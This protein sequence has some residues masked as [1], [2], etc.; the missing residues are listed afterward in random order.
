MSSTF[1]SLSGIFSFF[2]GSLLCR[3]SIS[4]VETNMILCVSLIFYAFIKSIL[5]GNS[6]QMDQVWSFA[7]IFYTF[8]FNRW[9]PRG[10]LMLILVII[11]GVRL[12]YNFWRKGGYS[13][14][15]DYRLTQLRETI[16]NPIH[17]G[18]FNFVFICCNQSVLLML[19][20][21]PCYFAPTSELNL[22]DLVVALVVIGF[23]LVETIADN[24]QWQFQCEKNRRKGKAGDSTRGFITNGLF[25]YSRHPNYF[26]EICI[27][28]GIYALSMSINWSCIGAV[29][30]TLHIHG[31]ATFTESISAKRYP[32]YS[33][34]QKSTSRIIPWFKTHKSITI[35]V[36]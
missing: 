14:E 21:L 28:W 35:K 12:S 29:L 36:D 3:Y 27:W 33:H 17:W 24:Q 10:N 20:S 16:T 31:S 9:S 11:W 26:A 34:H 2:L 13:G 1:Q 4:G 15:E 18:I 23:I 6:S 7:P 8:H 25:E 30:L 32:N 5:T 19:V 22:V